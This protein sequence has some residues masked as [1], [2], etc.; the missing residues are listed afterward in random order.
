MLAI[1]AQGARIETVESLAGPDGKMHPVQAAFV[2]N[3]AQQCGFCTPG[4]VMACKGFLDSNPTPTR[5]QALKGLGGNLC[6]CGTYAGVPRRCSRRAR[7]EGGAMAS[8]KWPTTDKSKYLAKPGILRIDGPPKV[9]GEAKYAYDINRPQMLFAKILSS[10]HPNATIR[11]IDISAAE[12]MPGVRA[13]SIMTGPA[14][15]ACPRSRAKLTPQWD[16]FEIAAVAADTEEI[17]KD[18]IRAIKVDYAIAAAPRERVR[19]RQS[20]GRSEAGA[21]DAARR[22]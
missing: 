12:K 10:P 3:D 15:P 18:A 17:A 13:I 16:G 9:K 5:E 6:R 19:P 20:A 2:N 4:F 11:S 21:G 7:R 14:P 1:E 22:H 8:P